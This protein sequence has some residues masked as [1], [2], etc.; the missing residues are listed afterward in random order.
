MK[1]T[2][3]MKYFH[4]WDNNY[5]NVE[6]IKHIVTIKQTSTLWIKKVNNRLPSFYAM[7]NGKLVTWSEQLL[8][9]NI[10]NVNN[11]TNQITLDWKKYTWIWCKL[12]TT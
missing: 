2:H 9:L 4:P 3:L 12:I 6:N 1:F 10:Q 5:T 11:S 8:Y 7:W